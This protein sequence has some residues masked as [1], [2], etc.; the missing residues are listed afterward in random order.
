MLKH[1]AIW[2]LQALLVFFVPPAHADAGILVVY[3]EQY[4]PYSW[5]EGTQVQGLEVELAEEILQRR[6]GLAVE[7]RVLPWAR[8]QA[9]VSM[10]NADFFFAVETPDRNLFSRPIGGGLIP[11]RASVFVRAKDGEELSGAAVSLEALCS[12]KTGAVRGNGWVRKHLPCGT[13]SFA[14]SPQALVRML[15]LKRTDLIVDDG[16]MLRSTARQLQVENDLLEIPLKGESVSIQFRISLKSQHQALI[17][18]LEKAIDTMRVDGTLKK[19]L[20]RYAEPLR[21]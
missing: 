5:Q 18:Q 13:L 12:P 3:A 6:M 19:I 9:D 1:I 8:A 7:H 17:P 10:G 11:W 15:L 16:L 21:P 4:R 2:G 20:G 14:N